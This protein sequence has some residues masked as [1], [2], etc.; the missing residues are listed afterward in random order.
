MVY[1]APGNAPD[2]QAR[3]K[4]VQRMRFFVDISDTTETNLLAG[5]LAGW[6]KTGQP[7]A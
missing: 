2:V 3:R 6:A 4:G 7:I 1:D 5:F